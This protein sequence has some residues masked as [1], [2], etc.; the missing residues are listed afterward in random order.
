MR[1]FQF[2][3]CMLMCSNFIFSQVNSEKLKSLNNNKKIEFNRAGD[4]EIG[5]PISKLKA[6]KEF[7]F[8]RIRNPYSLDAEDNS[9]IIVAKK[10]GINVEFT[11][12]EKGIYTVGYIFVT[13]PSFITATGFRVSDNIGKLLKKELYVTLGE[14]D[15][16]QI[17]DEL[18]CT[19]KN[20]SSISYFIDFS[21]SSNK[22]YIETIFKENFGMLKD[23]K[24]L[25]NLNLPISKIRI[26]SEPFNQEYI[27]FL[28]Q[29]N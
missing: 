6:N 18:V 2:C 21:K 12:K 24:L 4:I 22:K 27:D 9:T 14:I 28:K 19:E 1:S 17:G 5:M 25:Q 11:E 10:N 26:S 15:N 16:P 13:D 3:I 23:N 20:N 8:K 7:V 29:Q